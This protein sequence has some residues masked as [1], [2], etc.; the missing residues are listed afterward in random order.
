V[1]PALSEV[2]RDA[3]KALGVGLH[4]RR[5]AAN[6]LG[7]ALPGGE[8]FEH[9]GLMLGRELR[10]ARVVSLR[11]RLEECLAYVLR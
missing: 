1:T 7:H 3:D 11:R 10:Q 2:L 8:V 9:G 4:G 6:L 5:I